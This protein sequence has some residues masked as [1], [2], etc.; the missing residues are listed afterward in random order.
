LTFAFVGFL[1]FACAEMTYAFVANSLALLGDAAA[2]LVDAMTYVMN[3]VAIRRG[4]GRLML[5]GPL[6]SAVA[7]VAVMVYVLVDAVSELLA[8]DSDAGVRLP[9]VLAFGLANLGLDVLNMAFFYAFPDAYRAILTFGVKEPPKKKPLEA[10]GDLNIRSALTHVVA[11]TY[12]SIAVV[13]CAAIAM[14][15]DSVDPAKADAVGAVVVEVPV[16]LMCFQMGAAVIRRLIRERNSHD[17]KTTPLIR[18]DDAPAAPAAPAARENDD[19]EEANAAASRQQH[20]QELN[21]GPPGRPLSP[22]ETHV[23]S[24]SNDSSYVA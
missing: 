6:V 7:L 11:D 5:L 4:S 21:E 3:L 14:S 22:T 10:D 2:M 8:T 19:D 17:D 13:L 15:F 24:N 16:V 9:I 18:E 1:G 12:R 20:N 23:S